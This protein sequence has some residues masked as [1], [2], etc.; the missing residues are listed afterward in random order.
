MNATF[1]RGTCPQCGLSGKVTLS[2][3]R[4]QRNL[5]AFGLLYQRTEA[6]RPPS[7]DHKVISVEEAIPAVSSGTRP[8][9]AVGGDIVVYFDLETT[10][11]NT[12]LDRITQ[13]A[14]VA[15]TGGD[16]TEEFN[17]LVKT[18]RKITEG[19]TSV[20]G[21]TNEMLRDAPP[22]KKAMGDFLLWLNTLRRGRRVTL[23]AHNGIGYDYPLLFNEMWDANMTPYM[24]LNRAGVT[25][26]FD[27]CVWARFNVA[28]HKTVKL[29]CGR[30]SYS[31]DSLYRAVTG[32]SIENAHDAL[33]DCRALRVV[34]RSPLFSEKEVDFHTPN[35]HSCRSLRETV[36]RFQ[37]ARESIDNTER[38]NISD[39]IRT[40]TKRTLLN[41]LGCKP[42]AA[43][44]G[45]TASSDGNPRPSKVA[46]K[47]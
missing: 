27:S 23:I 16:R 45:G 22:F 41:F 32:K 28:P 14:A 6:A 39:R 46:K 47:K 1:E 29:D 36:D 33:S 8:P 20:T 34:C 44:E 19:A 2:F 38:R 11:L 35:G 40:S 42:P 18:E 3:D 26:M 9:P 37:T 25:A 24:T 5:S 12:M 15:E 43:K 21:L 30:P 10:G 13:I 4:D 17:T 31:N 7:S